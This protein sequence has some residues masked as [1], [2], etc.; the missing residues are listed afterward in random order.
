MVVDWISVKDQ[1]PP[2]KNILV[3]TKQ[4]CIHYTQLEPIFNE[5]LIPET[6]DGVSN[7][8]PG[9]AMHFDFWMELP[10]IAIELIEPQ[11]KEA[12]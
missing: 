5:Y 10:E 6:C 12:E 4:G 2:K 3:L 1:E 8:R 11:K 9:Q 7:H